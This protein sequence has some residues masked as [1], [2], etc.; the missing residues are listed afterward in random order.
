MYFMRSTI[1][2]ELINEANVKLANWERKKYSQKQR[3]SEKSKESID[4]PSLRKL[5]CELLC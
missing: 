4:K 5:Q 3:N 1:P 2:I